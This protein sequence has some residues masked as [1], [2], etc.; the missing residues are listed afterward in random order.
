MTWLYLKVL[1]WTN[2]MLKMNSRRPVLSHKLRL[3]DR[4]AHQLSKFVAILFIREIAFAQLVELD[5]RARQAWRIRGKMPLLQVLRSTRRSGI[6]P[7]FSVIALSRETEI[8][9]AGKNELPP[10]TTE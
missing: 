4:E 6:L 9:T 5:S 10:T 8:T 7:R 1:T 2:G 3:G